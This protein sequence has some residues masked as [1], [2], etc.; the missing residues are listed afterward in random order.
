MHSCASW[1]GLLSGRR[2]IWRIECSF[3]ASSRRAAL[4]RASGPP[5]RCATYARRWVSITIER[6]TAFEQGLAMIFSDASRCVAG[7]TI[8]L[9][10]AVGAGAATPEE[11]PTGVAQEWAA[12]IKSGGVYTQVKLLPK[13]TLLK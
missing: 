6:V 3:A 9:L 12:A 4:V 13:T 7:V 11:T 2:G 5:K 1:S 8:S 10:F